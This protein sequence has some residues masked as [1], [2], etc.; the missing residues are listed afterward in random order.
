MLIIFF[1]SI[2]EATDKERPLKESFS[3]SFIFPITLFFPFDEK[4]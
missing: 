2:S 1:L 3:F 4:E